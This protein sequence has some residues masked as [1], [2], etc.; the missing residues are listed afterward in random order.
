MGCGCGKGGGNTSA[1]R[2]TGTTPSSPMIFGMDAI[3]LPIRRVVLVQ[4]QSGVPAGA[5]R[6]AR[7]TEV[8]SLIASGVLRRTDG[9]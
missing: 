3:D 9:G 2:V 5:T 6:Y 8:E 7:G 4:G 1:E